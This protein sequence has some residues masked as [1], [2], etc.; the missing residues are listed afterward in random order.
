MF[1]S[2]GAVGYSYLIY[3]YKNGYIH[4]YIHMVIDIVCVAS[5][6][7]GCVQNSPY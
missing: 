6:L 4:I 7:K 5:H 1:L 3:R 2:C